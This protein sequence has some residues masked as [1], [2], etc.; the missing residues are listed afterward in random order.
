MHAILMLRRKDRRVSGAGQLV[1]LDQFPP[2]FSE[3]TDING[4]HTRTHI[5]IYI[6]LIWGGVFTAA[7]RPKSPHHL[8]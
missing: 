2:R 6:R 3:R 1:L 4:I 7:L 5:H 8:P